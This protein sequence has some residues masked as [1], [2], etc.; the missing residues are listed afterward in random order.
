MSV[1]TS[2]PPAA[3]G[4]APAAGRTVWGATS[5][6]KALE[7]FQTL[8]SLAVSVSALVL[9]RDVLLRTGV[10]PA[11]LPAASAPW[12]E[13][14]SQAF[15]IGLDVALGLAIAV[16]VI[17]GIV[18][19]VR[20]LIAWRRGVLAMAEG[21][22]EF[23]TPQV[24]AAQRARADHSR[25]LWLFLGYLFAAIGAAIAFAVLNA[26]LDAVN[27]PL[28][29]EWVSSTVSGIAT[30]AVLV[31]IYYFGGRH[32]DLLLHGLATPGEQAILLRG[33]RLLLVG[34]VVGLGAA[35]APLLWELEA[36]A[37]AS[38][39]LILLGAHDLQRAY[40]RWLAGE[41]P[42]ALPSSFGT[43]PGHA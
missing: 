17:I 41:R 14:Q 25:T 13:W 39:V 38:L 23:G 24:D 29:P 37:V 18:V 5:I 31:L 21:A 10:L 11:N 43:L 19:A 3:P 27:S 26:A 34:A 8:I 15:R 30:G 32:L 40:A 6:R 4:A 42:A 36:A 20:G 16:L 35:F 12:S 28:V 7:G 2:Y 1:A 33:R 9:V 22:S